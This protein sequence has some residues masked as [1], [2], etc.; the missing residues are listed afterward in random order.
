M[1]D[2]R[3]AVRARSLMSFIED[4]PIPHVQG[5]LRAADH[6]DVP[7]VVSS[8]ARVADELLRLAHELDGKHFPPQRLIRER[9]R[10]LLR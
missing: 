8:H 5:Q 7:E 2:E 4:D 9:S 3:V 10:T 1:R 6:P